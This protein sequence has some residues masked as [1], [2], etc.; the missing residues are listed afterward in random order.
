M[1]KDE[2]SL[3]VICVICINNFIFVEQIDSFDLLYKDM[4]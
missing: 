2:K 1:N 3:K 4:E